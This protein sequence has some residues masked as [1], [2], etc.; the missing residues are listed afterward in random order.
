M[1][2]NLSYYAV[3]RR[4]EMDAG[5][6]I[7][8]HDSKCCNLH[9]HR[10]VIEATC[11][12][13]YLHTIGEQTD[14][15]LDFNFLREEMLSVI[16]LCDH[17]FIVSLEDKAFL[18]MLAPLT[19]SIISWIKVLTNTVQKNGFCS[20]KNNKLGTL[21]YIVPFQPTAERLAKHWFEQLAPVVSKRSNGLA[22]LMSV[23]VL[24]T[25]NNRAKYTIQNTL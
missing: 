10:Y 7:M 8:T 6:R 17:G 18:T 16:G 22:H 3:T 23:A 21:L 15:A 9:G 20:T 12:A 1:S 5:H 19:Q 13:A 25:P 24:E 11:Y 2:N 14:M 4:I